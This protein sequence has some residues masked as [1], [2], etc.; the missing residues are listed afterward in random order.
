MM[1]TW[2]EKIDDFLEKGFEEDPYVDYMIAD[3]GEDA[4]FLHGYTD[5]IHINK[6]SADVLKDT[7]YEAVKA[8]LEDE[9]DLADEE[10]NSFITE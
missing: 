2:Q 7:N 9:F 1:K 4:V 5:D 3:M 6:F 8:G 10:G